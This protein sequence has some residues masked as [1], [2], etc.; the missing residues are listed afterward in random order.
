MTLI[1]LGFLLPIADFGLYSLNATNALFFQIV[2]GWWIT[3][4]AYKFMAHRDDVL[5]NDFIATMA[6][7]ACLA[8]VVAT[9]AAAIFVTQVSGYSLRIAGIV[10]LWT[11][12]L[13][14]YDLTLAANNGLGNS[15]A[16]AKLSMWRNLLA[17]V[18]SAGLVLAGYGP[19]G[20]M[21]GQALSLILPLLVLRSA[22][23]F[24][25][26]AAIGRASLAR[27][28]ELMR[29]GI[30]GMC[31]LGY[32]I[33]TQAVA[34]NLVETKLGLAAAGQFAFAVDIFNAPLLLVGTSFSLSRMRALYR[35]GN[36]DDPARARFEAEQYV[37]IFIVLGLAYAAVGAVVAPHLAGLL[38]FSSMGAGVAALAGPA[39]LISA[40][41]Q[42]TSAV[43]TALLVCERRWPVISLTLSAIAVS[44]AS[45]WLAPVQGL[46]ATG[47]SFAAGL[48]MVAIVGLAAVVRC[49]AMDLDTGRLLRSAVTA[50]GACGASYACLWLLGTGLL[51]A[52]AAGF[53]GVA[54]FA[55]LSVGLRTLDWRVFLYG[56]AQV[57]ATGDERV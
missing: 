24:W 28:G 35:S 54:V 52:V 13:I 7:A 47:W 33:L 19:I 30:A 26:R 42:V 16:Y 55:G 1:L 57:K 51:G 37:Q 36:K 20:A 40:A 14:A 18:L 8:S 17:L 4:A 56:S 21:I 15:R 32:Y 53:A 23:G 11:V 12:A 10:A 9:I 43:L 29:F 44:F 27:A 22:N 41:V 45:V 2:C 39:A 34:R 5:V 25:R 48:A 49:G 6:A 50:L 38:A 46:G 3:S 31:V